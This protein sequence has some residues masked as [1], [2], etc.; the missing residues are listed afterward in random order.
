MS[1]LYG[2]KHHVEIMSTISYHE[3]RIEDFQDRKSELHYAIASDC[4]NLISQRFY[5]GQN[6]T[7]YKQCTQKSETVSHLTNKIKLET[8]PIAK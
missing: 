7:C 8:V 5:L 6:D 3:W 1:Q 2:D 4:Q